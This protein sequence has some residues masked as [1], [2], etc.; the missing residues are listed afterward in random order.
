MVS[1]VLTVV[2][3]VVTVLLGARWR[4]RKELLFEYRDERVVYLDESVRKLITAQYR[5]ARI[6]GSIHRVRVSFCNGGNREIRA[7]DWERPLVVHFGTGSRVLET[8][9]V[10]KKPD[11]LVVELTADSGKLSFKCGSLNQKDSFAVSVLVSEFREGIDIDGRVLGGKIAQYPRG[12]EAKGIVFL[13]WLAVM[14]IAFL[15]VVAL[16][17]TPGRWVAF[18]VLLSGFVLSRIPEEGYR[19]LVRWALGL[20]EVE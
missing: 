3:I 14:V 5:D 19:E 7:D 18:V 20:P 1:V 2:G 13:S 9:V 12:E 10:S 16:D 15:S 8:N 17:W 11:T 6:D 4:P